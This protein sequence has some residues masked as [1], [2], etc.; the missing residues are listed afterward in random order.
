MSTEIQGD[1]VLAKGFRKS[2]CSAFVV[3]YFDSLYSVVIHIAQFASS[4][5]GFLQF[6]NP[7]L[8]STSNKTP[9]KARVAPSNV[10]KVAGGGRIMGGFKCRFKYSA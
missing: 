10:T 6:P 8:K 7:D 3:V 2:R 4:I 1:R 5:V 9:S